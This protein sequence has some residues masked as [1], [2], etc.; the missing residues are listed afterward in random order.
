LESKDGFDYST[1]GAQAATNTDVPVQ[2]G[3]FQNGHQS[4]L[5]EERGKF[6]WWTHDS[7]EGQTVSAGDE[8]GMYWSAMGFTATPTTGQQS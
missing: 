6:L 3:A 5:K 1:V 8:G 4:R 7:N 2:K